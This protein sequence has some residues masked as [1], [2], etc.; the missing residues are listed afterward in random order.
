[1]EAF[2]ILLGRNVEDDIAAVLVKD[3][4]LINGLQYNTV[5]KKD[6]PSIYMRLQ[7]VVTTRRN[8][9]F[10]L[11][12]NYLFD[13]ILNVPSRQES[14]C[15]Q[16]VVEGSKLRV[17]KTALV[18]EMRPEIFALNLIHNSH[19]HCPTILPFLNCVDSGYGRHSLIMPFY[20]LAVSQLTVSHGCIACQCC[21][22]RFGHHNGV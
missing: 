21:N 10:C 11:T 2:S 1:M 4:N 16:Y 18:A 6:V 12:T 19:Y 5:Q 8:E 13:G 20:G 15:M 3:I 9:T 7:S 17:A 22:V 14:T